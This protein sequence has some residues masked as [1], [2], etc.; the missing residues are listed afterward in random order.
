M[1]RD[2]TFS[3]QKATIAAGAAGVSGAINIGAESV[4]GI[5]QSG[6]GAWTAAVLEFETSFDGGA[7]WF[8]VVD[9]AAA[10]VSIASATVATGKA[11]VAATILNKLSGLAMIRLASGPAGA[12]VNQVNAPQFLILTKTL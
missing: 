8:P 12:R 6:G 3:Q 5:V 11:I 9:D 2:R 10:A 7:T 1:G 4:T